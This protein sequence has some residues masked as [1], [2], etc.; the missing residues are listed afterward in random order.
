VT[1]CST[2]AASKVAGHFSVS[3]GCFAFLLLLQLERWQDVFGVTNCSIAAASKVVGQ[4][5]AW[6]GC[7]WGGG[8]GVSATVGKAAGWEDVVMYQK[9]PAVV[10]LKL[11]NSCSSAKAGK[12]L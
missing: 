6:N 5:S 11:K 7:C 8:G 9:S 3:N 1:N 2:A 12:Q 10:V 4:F